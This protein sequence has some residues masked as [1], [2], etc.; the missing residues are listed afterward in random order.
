M[1]E[2]QDLRHVW[3]LGIYEEVDNSVDS[4]EELSPAELEQS[5]ERLMGIALYPSCDEDS[6][7]RVGMIRWMKKAAFDGESLSEVRII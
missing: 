7:K 3:C 6:F 2:V 1:L 5:S 4:P